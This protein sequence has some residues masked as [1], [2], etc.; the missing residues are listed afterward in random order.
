[1]LVS[2][3]INLNLELNRLFVIYC[4]CYYRSLSLLVTRQRTEI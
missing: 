2:T 4:F 1:M 3:R